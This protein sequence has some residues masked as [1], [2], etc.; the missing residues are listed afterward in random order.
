MGTKKVSYNNKGVNEL[1]KNKLVLYKINGRT[2]A[3]TC[4]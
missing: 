4:N 2:H 3:Y 1:P